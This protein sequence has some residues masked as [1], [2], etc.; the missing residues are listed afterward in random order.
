M[1]SAAGD[2]RWE[3]SQRQLTPARSIRLYQR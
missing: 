2:I 1:A 3:I